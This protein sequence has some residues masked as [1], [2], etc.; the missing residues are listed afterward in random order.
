MK[1]FKLP[2]WFQL[3]R[4]ERSS[5]GSSRRAL[6]LVLMPNGELGRFIWF[7][8][9]DVA[10]SCQPT[11][12]AAASSWTSVRVSGRSFGTC[13]ITVVHVG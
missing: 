4:A 10:V 2:R 12:A 9:D 11:A 5:N 8:Y 3:M 13:T 7:L 6:Q 1:K